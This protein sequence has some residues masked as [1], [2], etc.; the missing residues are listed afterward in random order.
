MSDLLLLI[1]KC[2]FNKIQILQWM[3]KV[4]EKSFRLIY[5]NTHLN[6]CE[7]VPLT[8]HLETSPMAYNT[9]Y[10]N[11]YYYESTQ[12]RAVTHQNTIKIHTDT[13]A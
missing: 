1:V 8:V 5:N 4:L 13:V 10:F 12:A 11:V 6:S 7:R 3:I 2:A 9:Q